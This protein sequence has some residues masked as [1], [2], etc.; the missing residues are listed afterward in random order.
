MGAVP[1][2]SNRARRKV[3]TRVLPEP[4]PAN[5]RMGL[6]EKQAASS[7]GPLSSFSRD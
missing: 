2:A 4:A 1:P 6:A 5:T 7:W 3:I